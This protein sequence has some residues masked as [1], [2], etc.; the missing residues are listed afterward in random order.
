[1]RDKYKHNRVKVNG[2]TKAIQRSLTSLNLLTTRGI[3]LKL[4]YKQIHNTEQPVRLK[5]SF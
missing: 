1:M 3:I 5:S 4:G 2:R